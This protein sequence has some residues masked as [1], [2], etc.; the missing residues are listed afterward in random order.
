MEQ[1]EDRRNLH[2]SELI[3]REVVTQ[4]PEPYVLMSGI[5]TSG[6]LHPGTLCE[7][8][9]ADAVSKSIGKQAGA[10]DFLFVAD[11]LDAFDSVPE[12]FKRHEKELTP[13]LGKP[14]VHVPDPEGCHPSFGE[15]FLAEAEEAMKK[16]GVEPQILKAS[17][18]YAAGKYDSHAMKYAEAKDE[19]KKI[20]QESSGRKEMPEHWHPIMPICKK[21]GK[22]A[23]T[24]VLSY[25]DGEY[26]YACDQDVKYTG[27]CGYRGKAKISGHEYKLL[28]RLDWAAR[29][30]IWNV[31]VEGG[32]VD[33]HTKGG[34]LQTVAAIEREFLKS[35]PPIFFKFGF[36]KYK[37]KKYSKSKGIGHTVAELLR[38]LPLPVLE[39]ALYR[40]DIQEDK[41]LVLE[42]KTL[43]PL[44]SDFEHAASLDPEAELSRPD[45]KKAISFSLT[46]G[47]P[48][49]APLLD[50]LI[51][52][53]LQK[54]WK[55]VGRLVED[56]KGVAYL[57]PFV[58]QWFERGWIPDKYVFE[59]R[60]APH[61]NESE[62]RD[63][64]EK[65]E[66]SMSAD[67]IQALIY[68]V[69]KGNTVAPAS[70]FKA[71]YLALI[72]KEKGPRLGPFIKIIGVEEAKKLLLK[73]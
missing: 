73:E 38:V 36:L 43:L 11:I 34:T 47:K 3:A 27:G 35:Q 21:C 64:A 60:G 4:K 1:Q 17:G 23:T 39:Y 50:I 49:G 61:E 72:G 67:E 59:L 12:P 70:L 63:F 57:A 37:G 18:N 42:E 40:P 20:V 46:Q 71:V 26:E 14:L 33:H 10:C 55:K 45:R 6:P 5:T 19:V 65:L 16:F 9:F 15:H 51:N 41:E 56:P 24:R 66:P 32:S 31:S 25:A 52:Y 48:W 29:H 8:L 58:D 44:V 62:V 7:F 54:D 2:W 13:H 28:F 53:S 69:A 68:D 30:Q 22:V